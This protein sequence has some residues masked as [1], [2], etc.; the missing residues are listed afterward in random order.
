MPRPTPR[1]G[2]PDDLADLDMLTPYATLMR[3]EGIVAAPRLDRAAARQMD[4]PAA[5]LGRGQGPLG[6]GQ[7]LR[8]P[9]ASLRS[10]PKGFLKRRHG[11]RSRT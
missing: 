7:P 3:Y 1:L 10:E 6:T 5:P 8:R 11:V 4:P 2:L 9:T